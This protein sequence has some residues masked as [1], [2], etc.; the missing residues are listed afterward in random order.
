MITCSYRYDLSG[1]VPFTPQHLVTP[2]RVIIVAFCRVPAV[3]ACMGTHSVI[4]TVICKITVNLITTATSPIYL[5][6]ITASSSSAKNFV[7]TVIFMASIIL[8]G[9]LWCSSILHLIFLHHCL[10][11]LQLGRQLLL[12]ALHHIFHIIERFWNN[13]RILS[14][15]LLLLQDFL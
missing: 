4:P 1:E 11:L 3:G 13:L 12:G 9:M 2:Q 10:N 5:V 8:V 15:G 6:L 7:S 14:W